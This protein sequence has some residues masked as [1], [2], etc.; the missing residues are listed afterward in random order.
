MH[1]GGR[2]TLHESKRS[3]FTDGKTNVWPKCGRL[4]SVSLELIVL[5]AL[6]PGLAEVHHS[7]CI[8]NFTI[9]LSP[10][11]RRPCVTPPPFWNIEQHL[12]VVT[13]RYIKPQ[14]KHPRLLHCSLTVGTLPSILSAVILVC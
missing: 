3:E 2:N 10:E 1:V 4:R 9:G 13:V 8:A 5:W 6:V 12:A 7:G 14:M 11:S